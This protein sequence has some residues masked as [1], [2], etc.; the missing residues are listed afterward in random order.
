MR[1]FDYLR[2]LQR[3]WWIP[4][5]GLLIG[6]LL[7]FVTQPS[8]ASVAIQTAP[9]S[10]FRAEHLLISNPTSTDRAGQNDLGFDRLSLLTITGPV[11]EAALRDLKAKGWPTVIHKSESSDSSS[12]A[13]DRSRRTSRASPR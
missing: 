12:P 2:I 9:K 7:A 3:R 8:E 6:M 11:R 10:Q 5:L 1:P 4:A 13:S